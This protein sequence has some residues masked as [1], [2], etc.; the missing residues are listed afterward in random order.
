MLKTLILY[1]GKCDTTKKIVKYTSLIM[2]QA[3]LCSV[4]EF[5]DM[6][7]NYDLFIIGTSLC[8]ENNSNDIFYFIIK[9]I[10]WIREKKIV[11]FCYSN[12]KEKGEIYLEFIRNFLEEKLIYSKIFFGKLFI[13]EIVDFALNLSEIRGFLKNKAPEQVIKKM[14][15]EFLYKN[16]A[17]TLCTSKEGKVRGTPIEYFY[18]EGYIYM[19][20]DGGEKYAN[21]LLNP[22][23]SVCIYNDFKDMNR[24]QSVQ[25][26]GTA[27]IVHMNSKE[28]SKILCSRGLKSDRLIFFP[29]SLNLLKIRP[30]KAEYI[31]YKFVEMG[32]EKK[33][34]YIFRHNS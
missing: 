10:D 31:C 7:I 3:K 33:Q 13:N 9:N 15:E 8:E 20:T 32:Y 17:C 16:S 11:F 25:L 30:N 22:N 18:N 6:Y 19:L 12:L 23:V 21:I 28:Y 34:N 1:E 4:S 26:S 5:T 29:A 14:L 27:S 2:G 24:I